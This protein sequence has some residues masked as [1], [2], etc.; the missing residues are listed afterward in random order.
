[1][2]IELYRAQGHI[3]MPWKNGRGVT[4]QMYIWPQGATLEKGDFDLR[5]SSALVSSGGPFSNFEGFT[6]FLALLSGP[7]MILNV[8]GQTKVIDGPSPFCF[9]GEWAVTCE[10]PTSTQRDLNLFVRRTSLLPQVQVTREPIKFLPRFL[11]LVIA[12]EGTATVDL[13]GQSHNLAPLDLLVIEGAYPLATLTPGGL[14]W[15]VTLQKR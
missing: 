3:K 11:S 7:K 5:V 8:E 6:R 15:L 9:E 4:E 2:S 10:E 12:L 13:E 14:S 1:M